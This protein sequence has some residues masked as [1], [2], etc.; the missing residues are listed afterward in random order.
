[1]R[2]SDREVTGLANILAIL[3]KCK[4]IRIG[5]S[6]GGK[7]Y[8]VPMNFA[9]EAMNE[10]LFIYLHC[11]SEGRKLDIIKN[12]NNVCFEADC[13]CR[14]LE[15]AEPCNWSAEYESVI[16]EGTIAM[17]SDEQQKAEALDILMRRY[18]YRGAPYYNRQTLEKVTVLKISVTSITGKRN[19]KKY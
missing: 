14:I 16:G 19:K 17:L 13:S 2:R 12:N 7:P 3:D 18:G 5:L 9:Y 1:M 4:V 15:G 10:E 8:V 6:D 11:A